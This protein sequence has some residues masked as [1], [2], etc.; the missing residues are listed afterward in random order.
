[1]DA[2]TAAKAALRREARARRDALPEAARNAAARA[3][4]AEIAGLE[5]SG[6]VAAYWPIGSEIDPRPVMRDL[7]ARGMRVALP[8]VVARG[9][10]LS[11]REWRPGLAL[12]PAGF[13][14]S[15]PPPE[16]PALE[17]ETLLVPLLAFDRRGR[18]L[19]YGGGYYDRTLAALRARKTVRA[20]GLAFAEQEVAAVPTAPGDERLDA[21][22][23]ER[24]KLRPE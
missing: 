21:I 15:V 19:G 14:L 9:A 2:I 20:I 22:A 24:G 13:G 17:P 8:V 5:L 12:V 10:P 7:A 6:I 18:R 16:A 1:M 4:R 3:L 11:F 23:T